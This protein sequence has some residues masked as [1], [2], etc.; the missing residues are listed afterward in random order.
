[1]DIAKAN[2]SLKAAEHCYNEGLNN[3]SLSR[4]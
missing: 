4:A 3:S 2:E 1:M